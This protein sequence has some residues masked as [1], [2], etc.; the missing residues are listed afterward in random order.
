MRNKDIGT[1]LR[2]AV[3]TAATVAAA[4]I[5]IAGCGVKGPL[6]LPPAAP[7]ATQSPSAPPAQPPEAMPAEPPATSPQ[8]ADPRKP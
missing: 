7:G 5:L 6:K 8:P 2:G 3:C 1:R 4:A